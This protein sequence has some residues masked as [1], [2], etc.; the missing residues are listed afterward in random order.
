MLLNCRYLLLV[1]YHA[2]FRHKGRPCS[3]DEFPN[4]ST[5]DSPGQT[6]AL[7]HPQL[8]TAWSRNPVFSPAALICTGLLIQGPPSL[9]FDR[10]LLLLIS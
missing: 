9:Y 10:L 6:A 5:A 7:C 8:W 1:K 2:P 3:S 4:G